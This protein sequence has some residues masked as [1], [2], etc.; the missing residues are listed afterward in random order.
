MQERKNKGTSLGDELDRRLL[1]IL[2]RGLVE[3]R[4]LAL[5]Q[6]HI[7]ISELADALE[8]IPSYLDRRQ[9]EDL[10]AIHF[11]LRKFRERFPE[12]PHDYLQYLESE[13]PPAF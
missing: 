3:A 2:H 8:L 1:F 11:S 7:Q 10:D 9:D 4:N 12:S 6:P 13:A 5:S